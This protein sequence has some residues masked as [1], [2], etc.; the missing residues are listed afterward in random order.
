MACF[1]GKKQGQILLSVR[2]N[3][4]LKAVCVRTEIRRFLHC[5]CDFFLC[6]LSQPWNGQPGNV[7][8]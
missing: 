8:N 3:L 4:F 6:R 5:V 2:R 7:V 1:P